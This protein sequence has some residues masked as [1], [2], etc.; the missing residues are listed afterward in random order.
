MENMYSEM[1]REAKEIADDFRQEIRESN[2]GRL[3]MNKFNP[4]KFGIRTIQVGGL[5]CLL[6]LGGWGA[7]A[8][9]GVYNQIQII[10]NSKNPQEARE[11]VDQYHKESGF[12]DCAEIFAK[13]GLAG[14]CALGIGVVGTTQYISYQRRKDNSF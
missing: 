7:S 10:E 4:I 3:K 12:D 8:T 14:V 6:G 2:Y 9:I 5:V 11:K 13:I 1:R